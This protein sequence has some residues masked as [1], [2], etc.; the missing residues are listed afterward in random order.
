MLATIQLLSVAGQNAIS[1]TEDFFGGLDAATFMLH[2]HD[3][4]FYLA[5]GHGR[6]GC[7]IYHTFSHIDR[8][9]P[10]VTS[11][12]SSLEGP[13]F[14]AIN[15]GAGI[16]AIAHKLGLPT[17]RSTSALEQQPISKQL[18]HRR[19]PPVSPQLPVSSQLPP[20]PRPRLYTGRKPKIGPRHDHMYY[21]P[22]HNEGSQPH[23]RVGS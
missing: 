20:R 1:T 19:I 13:L 18:L 9:E 23:A 15:T 11:S 5:R 7:G 17:R 2:D 14:P 4:Y 16:G 21:H 3:H 6:S 8:P 12:S 10:L 22:T